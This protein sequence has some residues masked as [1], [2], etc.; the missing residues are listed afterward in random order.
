MLSQ[1]VATQVRQ[2]KRA[3]QEGDNTSRVRNFLRMNP[4]SFTRSSTT[5]DLENFMEELKKVF[6]VMNV[7]NSERVELATYY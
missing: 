7:V 2:H 3:R 6:K 5:E 4:P 1:V